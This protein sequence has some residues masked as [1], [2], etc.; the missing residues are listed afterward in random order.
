[1]PVRAVHPDGMFTHECQRCGTQRPL[2]LDPTRGD[3][4]VSASSFTVGPCPM[5]R[6]TAG[7][8]VFEVFRRDIPA[9]EA[10]EAEHP[11]SLAGTRL[12]GAPLG[13][14]REGRFVE[15]VVTEH[16]IGHIPYPER[17]EQCRLIRAMQRHPLLAAHAP[18]RDDPSVVTPA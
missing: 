14:P 12:Q 7:L 1:M 3:L 8:L 6:D 18:L 10:L 2:S 16:S 5:C 11:L 9:Y 4:G 15:N 13:D 17:V